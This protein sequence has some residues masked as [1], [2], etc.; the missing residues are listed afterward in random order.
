MVFLARQLLTDTIQKELTT[1][2]ERPRP[3]G[4]LKC[5]FQGIP[6][7]VFLSIFQ[8]IPQCQHEDEESLIQRG[9]V[10]MHPTAFQL[11]GCLDPLYVYQNGVLPPP[12]I[13]VSGQY[14]RH[15]L[16]GGNPDRDI[17]ITYTIGRKPL[18]RL[19][20]NECPRCDFSG[21]PEC[22]FSLFVSLQIHCDSLCIYILTR[23]HHF[24]YT[25]KPVMCHTTVTTAFP[26][27]SLH[28]SLPWGGVT[29]SECFKLFNN[30]DT[31]NN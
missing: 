10:Q 11:C 23:S 4:M 7:S 16:I 6:P 3:F 25:D 28:L 26:I 30:I 8:R 12:F 9:R 22:M 13:C 20:H 19:L 31:L 29:K 21:K 2:V 24:N 18:S 1:W 15:V 27:C 17:T 5:S 14:G